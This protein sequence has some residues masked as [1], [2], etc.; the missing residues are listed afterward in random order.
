MSASDTIKTEAVEASDTVRSTEASVFG[1]ISSHETLDAD[2]PWES[3]K[4]ETPMDET[5]IERDPERGEAEA[6]T[7]SAEGGEGEQPRPLAMVIAETTEEGDSGVPTV[8]SLVPTPGFHPDWL[9]A[10]WLV[11]EH[12]RASGKRRD[13]YYYDPQSNRKFRS[14][15]EVE[16][17]LN[18]VSPQTKMARTDAKST[19]NKKF[20]SIKGNLGSLLLNL[21]VKEITGRSILHLQQKL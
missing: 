16:D 5:R 12:Q 15:R 14:K 19:A 11:E 4:E 20:P 1:S 18:N 3:F 10:N 17:Y 2:Q 7:E 9:P 8:G 13:K 21:H 6:E